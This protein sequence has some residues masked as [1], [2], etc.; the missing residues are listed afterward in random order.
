[1][2]TIIEKEHK[3]SGL[4]LEIHEQPICLRCEGAIAR[5]CVSGNI[6]KPD[7]SL[8]TVR[9]IRAYCEHCDVLYEVDSQL[10][11]GMWQIVGD[12]R[13]VTERKERLSYLKRI[14]HVRGL[15]ERRAC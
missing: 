5:E 6:L 7:D 4:M 2:T 12:V 3:L 8:A 10:R 13:T 14:E 1:M 9:R 15:H 11:N